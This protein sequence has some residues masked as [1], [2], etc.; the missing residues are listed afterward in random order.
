MG[1]IN[2]FYAKKARSRHLRARSYFKLEEID[3][4]FSCIN[5]R[6]VIL[7]LGSAPGSWLQYC[8]QKTRGQARLYGVDLKSIIPLP[9][10][11][12]T[13]IQK[14]VFELV[15]EDIAEPVDVLLSDMSPKTTGIHEVDTA[16]SGD[17]VECALSLALSHLKPEG[18]FVAKHLQGENTPKLFK[19]IQQ[20][21]NQTKTFKPKS[22]RS[23]SSE[24]FF[25]AFSKK[26]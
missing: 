1:Y 9:E 24:F 26:R 2:D 14:S 3:N 10:T 21:F 25:I 22:S 19:Q 13:L 4:K 23:F 8:S 17:L 18:I 12:I 11:N 20:H 7:D 6:Q 15:P 5:K 16:A